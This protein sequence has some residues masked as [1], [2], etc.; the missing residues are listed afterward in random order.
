MP[1]KALKAKSP[2]QI[3]RDL[4]TISDEYGQVCGKAGET[5]FKMKAFEADLNQFNKRLVELNVEYNQASAE[6]AKKAESAITTPAT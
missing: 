1:K 3:V 2:I 4:K 5:Q 6:A